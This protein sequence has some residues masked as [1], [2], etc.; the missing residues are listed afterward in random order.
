MDKLEKFKKELVNL[1]YFVM[2][3][4]KDSLSLSNNFKFTNTD[5]INKAKELIKMYEEE[6]NEYTR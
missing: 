1:Q 2:C 3:V 6:L 5:I 4:T